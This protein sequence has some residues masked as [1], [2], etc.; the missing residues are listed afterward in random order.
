MDRLTS[1]AVFIKVA[2]CGSFAAAAG[3]L[4]ISA[5]MVGKHI[6]F[7]EQRLGTRLLNRTTRRQSL[8]AIGQVFYQRCKSV[9]AEADAAENVALQLSAAPR[10]QLRINAPVTFGAY[11]L[12]PLINRYLQDYPEVS[13]DLTL[14]DRFVD[15]IDEGYE[16]VIR[17]GELQDTGLIA[18]EL[19][20]YQ[21][22]ACAAPA[23]LEKHG[24]PRIPAELTRHECLLYR[25]WSPVAIDE[26]QFTHA[27]ETLRVRVNSRLHIND[28][29]ALLTAALNAGGILLAAESIVRPWLASGHL[30]PIL[31]DYQAPARAMHILFAASAP[32]TPK[33]RSF[34][35]YVV[36]EF[37][38]TAHKQRNPG[39]EI[40][41]SG[42]ERPV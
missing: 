15:L 42:S 6:T 35:D 27:G 25:Y 38:M 19:M 33:L 34:I 29:S 4:G 31:A 9:L 20:P 26:W 30:L 17:L 41:R 18:R 10:G 3:A 12:T 22:I 28:S 5:Q 39:R 37:G 16:A 8:T 7:L 40:P 21:L 13:V 24:T 36:A 14:N 1:M 11:A 23:Y 2:D 32:P